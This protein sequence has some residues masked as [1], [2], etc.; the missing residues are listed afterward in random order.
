MNHSWSQDAGWGGNQIKH[1]G[2]KAHL[3][4]AAIND[5][6]N[7]F[8]ETFADVLGVGGR[9]FIG[10]IGAGRGQRKTAS[11]NYRLH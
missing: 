2:F 10:R 6:R 11:A 5:Q 9:K 3:S 1:G 4:L 8:S 7:S